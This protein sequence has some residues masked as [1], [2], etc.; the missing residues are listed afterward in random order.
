MR[1]VVSVV[2]GYFSLPWAGMIQRSGLTA[3]VA[4]DL[5]ID[6]WQRLPSAW[7]GARLER[8]RISRDKILRLLRDSS[9][10]A[11]WEFYFSFAFGSF[12]RCCT[13][14]LGIF[15]SLG[16]TGCLVGFGWSCRVLDGRAGFWIQGFIPKV[17]GAGQ[18]VSLPGLILPTFPTSAPL[19]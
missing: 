2:L 19:G 1:A 12:Y 16:E 9:V 3:A 15:P 10:M 17:A 11:I 4:A 7:S 8:R 13:I 5:G 6:L 14:Y 18:V